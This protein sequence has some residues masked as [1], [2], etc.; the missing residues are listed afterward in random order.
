MT[1]RCLTKGGK[2][3]DWAK[4]AGVVALEPQLAVDEGVSSRELLQLDRDRAEPVV[5]YTPPIGLRHAALLLAVCPPGRIQTAIRPP[6]LLA[7]K[8]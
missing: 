1:H 7:M 4:D 3:T 8:V 6:M 2:A 5:F